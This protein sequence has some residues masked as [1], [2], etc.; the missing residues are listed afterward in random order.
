ME[1]ILIIFNH[2]EAAPAQAMQS[3]IDVANNQAER[4]WKDK[5]KTFT[6]RRAECDA[7]LSPV[8]KLNFLAPPGKFNRPP[9]SIT[10]KLDELFRNHYGPDELLM[11]GQATEEAY[12]VQDLYARELS[13]MLGTIRDSYASRAITSLG[14][15]YGKTSIP[16]L[17]IASV[18]WLWEVCQSCYYKRQLSM[19]R[20]ARSQVNQSADSPSSFINGSN[21]SRGHR[22]C[23]RL[24]ATTSSPS[25]D[26]SS[27][28]ERALLP[29]SQR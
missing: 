17:S 14:K 20:L 11:I 5:S 2:A 26:L 8:I 22:R 19:V 1:D 12:H 28:K 4:I 16:L 29:R 21:R 6:A 25:I 10:G 9:S 24:D 18:S 7:V 3:V 15:M 27:Q 23:G 13:T